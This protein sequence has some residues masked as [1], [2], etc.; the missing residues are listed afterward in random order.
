MPAI[1]H[2]TEQESEPQVG[3]ALQ[4]LH[5]SQFGAVGHNCDIEQR[6]LKT[7]T[8]VEAIAKSL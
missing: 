6:K 7:A 2:Y 3:W 8:S 1:L 4:L 5:I